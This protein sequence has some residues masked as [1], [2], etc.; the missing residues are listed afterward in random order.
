[1]WHNAFR[2]ASIAGR[3]WRFLPFLVLKY[4]HKYH[5]PEHVR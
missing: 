5:Q 3:F 1:M 2:K 4:H